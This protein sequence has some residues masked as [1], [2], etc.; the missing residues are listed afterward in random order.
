MRLHFNSK[1]YRKQYPDTKNIS[2]VLAHFCEIGWLERRNPSQDFDTNYYLETYPDVL[3]AKVNPFVHYLS[4]KGENR[5]PKLFINNHTSCWQCNIMRDFFNPKYYRAKYLDVHNV[6]D[7]L[8]HFCETGWQEHRNPNADF[9]TEYYLNINKDVLEAKINPF[10]HYLSQPNEGRLPK[11]KD[12]IQ[13]K[14]LRAVSTVN[15]ISKNYKTIKPNI[16]FENKNVLLIKLFSLDSD[17]CVSLSH[18]DYMIHTGGVQ[19]FIKLESLALKE[20]GYS[21][22]NL[23]PTVPN[24]KIIEGTLDTLLLNCYLDNVFIGTFSASEIAEVFNDLKIKRNIFHTGVIHSVMGW[25]ISTIIEIFKINFKY[26]F[27]YLHDY[28]SLCH[29]YR[30]LRNNVT[31][32][33]APS[34][35]SVSCSICIHKSGREHHLSQFESLFNAVKPKLIF[36]SRTAESV[37]LHSKTDYQLESVVIPHIRVSRR[38][39]NVSD[40]DLNGEQ[41]SKVIRVAFCGQPTSQKGYFHFV[42]LVDRCLVLD[43]LEFMHFGKESGKISSISFIEAKLEGGISNMS[44]LLR[45]HEIDIVFL[46]STW[47]ETFNYVAYEA[48]KAGAAIITLKDS[49]NIADYVSTNKIGE[50]VE[51]ITE[52]V[53]LLYRKD[54]KK[55]ISD[56]KAIIS[57]LDFNDNRSFRS[58]SELS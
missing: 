18:D 9:D 15:F 51:N 30:L 17:L 12:A 2:D 43:D 35:S 56:W 44:N 52:A 16:S 49:G 42:E 40:D 27:F 47:R 53:Q 13:K 5:L 33:D 32:C 3:M 39:L 14:L 21:Y 10:V 55:K 1:Y 37:F 6:S 54:I 58:I 29:E 4:Q 38:N 45:E 26:K 41:V 50:V 22:L 36:P 31:P 48:T 25:N 28:F 8:A 20:D 7:L 34:Y 19:Q 57:D 46:P 23:H 24:N 11:P